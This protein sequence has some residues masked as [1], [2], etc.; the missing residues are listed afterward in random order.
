[1]AGDKQNVS[2]T[3]VIGKNRGPEPKAGNAVVAGAAEGARGGDPARPRAGME[4]MATSVLHNVGNVLNS[5][6]VSASVLETRLSQSKVGNLGRAVALMREHQADLGAYLTQDPKGRQLSEYLAQVAEHLAS[7][8]RLMM[9]EVESLLKN[10]RHIEDIVAIQQSYARGTGLVETARPADLV[11]DA[12]RLNAAALERH[13]VTIEREYAPDA[14]DIKVEKHKVLQILVNLIR[15]A[16]YACD[17]SQA[18]D[19]RIIVRVVREAQGVRIVV[20]DNGVGIP[21]E[22]LDRIF[23]RGFTTRKDGHGFGL[24]GSA[25]TAHDLGGKLHAASDGPGK[26]AVFTLDLPSGGASS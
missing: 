8:Q 1:M 5:V 20:S 12:L 17:E 13:Q 6:K 2:A 11:E 14:P 26:G 18:A 3:A 24:S 4:E 23:T 19:R 25:Q 7:E 15:N 9:A 22:N 16:K 21:A 10:I